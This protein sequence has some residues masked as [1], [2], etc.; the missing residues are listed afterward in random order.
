[1][2]VKYMQGRGRKKVLFGT[3]YPMLTPDA[4]LQD[5]ASLGLDEE[6]TRL[7]L[8]DNAARIFAA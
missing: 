2:L 4:C 7:F 1:L 6:A 8:H 3:N 5:L